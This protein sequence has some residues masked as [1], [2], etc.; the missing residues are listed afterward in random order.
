MVVSIRFR[1]IATKKKKKQQK[2]HNTNKIDNKLNPKQKNFDK[3]FNS[4]GFDLA[5]LFLNLVFLRLFGFFVFSITKAFSRP[6]YDKSVQGQ[7]SNASEAHYRNYCSCCPENFV[8]FSSMLVQ[9]Q[10]NLGST[11]IFNS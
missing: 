1:S 10:K 8:F 5:E 9:L 3:L 6:K 4:S 7:I 11:Q 2:T